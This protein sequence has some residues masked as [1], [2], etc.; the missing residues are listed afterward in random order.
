MARAYFDMLP[1]N[2]KKKL[3]HCFYLLGDRGKIC[4]KEKFRYEGDQLFVIKSSE[5]R[6]FCFFFD[7]SK[8]ILTNAYEKKSAR[9][10]VREKVKALRVKEDY[11]RRCMEGN[12]YGQ[13]N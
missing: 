4:S 7:G 9:M 1:F 10:P 6:L 5:D 12:Y 2:R 11:A 8:I 13:K 3:I